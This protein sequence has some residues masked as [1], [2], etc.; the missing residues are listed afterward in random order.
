MRAES[1][2]INFYEMCQKIQLMIFHEICHKVDFIFIKIFNHNP[3]SFWIAR[4]FKL[5][6]LTIYK[7]Y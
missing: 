4:K 5:G 7:Y 6:K 1:S 3:K 2:L